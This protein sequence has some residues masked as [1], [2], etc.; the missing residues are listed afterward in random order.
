MIFS[1]FDASRKAARPPGMPPLLGLSDAFTKKS[2]SVLM[3]PINMLIL[4]IKI[5][6]AR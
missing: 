3:K 1:V 2:P 4:F 5:Q 6:T